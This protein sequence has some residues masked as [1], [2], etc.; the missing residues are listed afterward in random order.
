MTNCSQ[1]SIAILTWKKDHLSNYLTANKIC[2]KLFGFKKREDII[3]VSDDKLPCGVSEFADTFREHDAKVIKTKKPLKLLEI[4]PCHNNDWRIFITKKSPNFSKDNLVIG[5][6]GQAFDITHLFKNMPD[7]ISLIQ[8]HKK[9]LKQETYTLSENIS[10]SNRQQ[11]IIWHLLRGKSANAIG[12]ELNL[13]RRTIETYIDVLKYKFGVKQKPEL[14]ESCL[15]HGY[16]NMLPA[17]L[18]NKQ[19]SIVLAYNNGSNYNFE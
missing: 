18:L 2:T 1:D 15:E 13:S 12:R 14:I 11:E 17:T 7:M 10:L 5:T 16:L 6:Y 8:K 4:Q 9:I 19:L 3:G